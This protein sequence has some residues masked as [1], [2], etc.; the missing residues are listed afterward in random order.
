MRNLLAT[1]GGKTEAKNQTAAVG[2]Y[3]KTILL[4]DGELDS[5]RAVSQLLTHSGCLVLC[6]DSIEAA[7]G[8][9]SSRQ[10]DLILL[11]P[12]SSDATASRHLRRLLACEHL[13]GVP[14]VRI[15]ADTGSIGEDGR[16][17]GQVG[18]PDN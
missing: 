13:V 16:F 4:I 10:P 1:F 14:I 9:L 15:S 5:L 17:D 8:K 12:D 18:P 2:G 6:S 11:V 3:P 7:M